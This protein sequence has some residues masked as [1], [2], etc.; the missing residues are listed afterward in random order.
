[1]ST[2]FSF[3]GALNLP[4]DPTLPPE[5]IPF[6]FSSAFDSEVKNRLTLTGSGTKV[7]NFGT[8]GNSGVKYLAVKVET[9]QTA[10]PVQL[11][12]NGG[13]ASGEVEVSPGG[14]VIVA[15]P[16]PAAG[17]SALSIIYTAN[18]T[19]NIWALG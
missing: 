13:G 7:I 10:A 8:I 6:N 12:F 11:Q 9:G 19:V 4:G 3:T 18:T 1:M 16:S 5:P 14:F 17:I 15:S 2:P